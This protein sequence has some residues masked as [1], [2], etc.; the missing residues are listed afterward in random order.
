MNRL[1]LGL[2]GVALALGM[3]SGIAQASPIY[4]IFQI[5]GSITASLNTISWVDNSN[6]ANQYVIGPPSPTG[7]FSAVTLNSEGAIQNLSLSSEPVGVPFS[8]PNWLTMPAPDGNLSITLTFIYAGTFGQA[9]CSAPAAPNQQCTPLDAAATPGPFNLQNSSSGITSSASFTFAGIVTDGN[10]ADNT[11][12]TGQFSVNFPEP[13]QDVL[14]T[15]ASAGSVTNTYSATFISMPEPS[16]AFLAL[17]GLLLGA[18]LLAK[19][20]FAKV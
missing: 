11:P 12:I 15:L 7:S 3:S 18:A 9:E 13:Y 17:G 10:P 6:N 2:F 16:A 19:R 4:G 20:K 14:G 5:D 8:D 1:S